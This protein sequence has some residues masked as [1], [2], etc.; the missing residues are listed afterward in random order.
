VHRF[1][2]FVGLQWL[3]CTFN[4]HRSADDCFFAYIFFVEFSLLLLT[5]ACQCYGK[6][7]IIGCGSRCAAMPW[8]ACRDPE[9]TVTALAMKL[10]DALRKIRLLRRVKAENG[11][12]DAEA[13]NA[14][15]IIRTL[16]DRFAVKSEETRPSN[17]G[18]FRMSWVYWD[19]VLDDHGLQLKHFG[20]RGS[21]SISRDTQAI[22]RLDTGEWRVQRGHNGSTEVVAQGRGVETFETYLSKNAPQMFSLGSAR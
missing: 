9:E 18:P 21:A 14:A 11:A 13:E 5:S 6:Y 10:E 19:H 16:M 4:F 3:P 15:A 7:G 17:E 12:S 22:M 20:K 8:C 1:G 2:E